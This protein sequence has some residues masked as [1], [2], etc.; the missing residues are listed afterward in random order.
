MATGTNRIPSQDNATTGRSRNGLNWHLRDPAQGPARLA[1]KNREFG[2]CRELLT[3]TDAGY[4]RLRRNGRRIRRNLSLHDLRSG[5]YKVSHNELT[6]CVSDADSF[7]SVANIPST[8]VTGATTAGQSG[9]AASAPNTSN[10]SA[11][12]GPDIVASF[13][14]RIGFR[15]YIALSFGFS[16]AVNAWIF[17]R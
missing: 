6:R 4:N 17:F 10:L 16:L 12:H 5:R 1:V 7:S 9:T 3:V 11:L 14:D 8:S 15:L 13:T 2:C